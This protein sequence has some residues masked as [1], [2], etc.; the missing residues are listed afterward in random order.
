MEEVG[1]VGVL[2]P[3]RRDH[4]QVLERRRGAAPVSDRFDFTSMWSYTWSHHRGRR[5]PLPRRRASSRRGRPRRGPRAPPRAPWLAGRVRRRRRARR[6]AAGPPRGGATPW[7]PRGA[8]D[9]GPDAA[10]RLTPPRGV[11]ASAGGHEREEVQDPGLEDRVAVPAADAIASSSASPASS[12]A[13]WS[14]AP[15]RARPARTPGRARRPSGGTR[16]RPLPPRA[17]I[18]GASPGLAARSAATVRPQA[19]RRS[20]PAS[21]GSASSR[22]RWATASRSPTACPS[23]ATARRPAACPCGARSL[24]STTAWPRGRAGRLPSGRARPACRSR[25]TRRLPSSPGAGSSR[26]GHA[27][28]PPAARCWSVG[29]RRRCAA[30]RGAGTRG[31]RRSGP[32]S[33]EWSTRVVMWSSTSVGDRVVGGDLVLLAH[34]LGRLQR[35]RRREDAEAVEDPP[36]RR[37]EQLS[38]TTPCR[39]G[40]AGGPGRRR[41]G[42]GGAGRPGGSP[43][44]AG[45]APA[46]GW[47]PARWRAA[48]GRAGGRCPRPLPGAPPGRPG[49]APADRARSAN[50]ATAAR[51]RSG[52]TG[53]TN[54]PSTP[55]GRR[56]VDSTRTSAEA[57]STVPTTEAHASTTCS[58]LSSTSRGGGRWLRAATSAGP[59]SGAW[60]TSTARVPATAGETRSDD[61]TPAR[62][63]SHTPPGCCSSRR[64]PTPAPGGSCPRRRVPVSV[65]GGGGEGGRGG[66]RGRGWGGGGEVGGGSASARWP[67][68]DGPA[69]RDRAA[70]GRDQ[71]ELV[72]TARS[73][74]TNAMP[75]RSARSSAR[76]RASA[77]VVLLA[78]DEAFER[79][80][81]RSSWSMSSTYPP[82]LVRRTGSGS[83]LASPQHELLEGL[84]RRGRGRPPHIVDQPLRGNNRPASRSRRARTA[85]WRSP[86]SGTRPVRWCTS[87]GP[88]MA[89][90]ITLPDHTVGVLPIPH[91]SGTTSC[92][93][94]PAGQIALPLQPG[95][96]PQQERHP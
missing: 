31:R 53:R 10:S 63:T 55:S 21:S 59:T 81:S 67:R 17:A 28:P 47:R 15:S 80:A 68:R 54:S 2:A 56:L 12:R 66:E 27:S 61:P 42:R 46:A 43:A 37:R 92:D 35:Q 91:R 57:W 83:A 79:R 64:R 76:Q 38:P 65:G 30:S 50:S 25:R 33:N 86:P 52:R 84:G 93:R 45:P 9:P 26:R 60:R 58:Q 85:R 70:P 74:A 39:G 72:E 36:R 8:A 73:G 34:R 96:S 48:G 71:P 13:P 78:G 11:V 82:L 22:S 3:L 14:P 19:R 5:G 90:C 29:P 49:L 51:S 40:C 24:R 77:G 1:P 75:A 6:G 16:R 4:G 95:L 32:A 87:S 44:P 69:S 7:P 94:A 18:E 88:R 89:N 20:A 23:T 62:S 41:D